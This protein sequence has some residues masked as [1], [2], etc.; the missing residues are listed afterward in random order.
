MKLK[1]VT[2]R[3]ETVVPYDRKKIES[4]VQKAVEA[5]T[6]YSSDHGVEYANKLGQE[7]AEA[8]ERKLK[9]GSILTNVEAI[10]DAV[11]TELMAKDAKVAKAF[12]LYREQ[13][14][15][16]RDGGVMVDIHK[17]IQ[18]YLGTEFEEAEQ[19]WRKKENANQRFGYPGLINYTSGAI[20][21]IDALNYLYPKEIAE[22]HKN[23]DFHIHDL[24]AGRIGYCA[25]WSLKD[26][27]EKGFVGGV[28]T[29]ASKPAK[30]L[31]SM[32]SQLFNF[33]S[34]LQAEWA[35]AQA[36]NSFDTLLAPFVRADNL[37]YKQ[38]KQAMQLFL[39][40]LNTGLRLGQCVP[41]TTKCLTAD[42]LWVNGDE[43]KV[44]DKIVVCDTKTQQFGIDTVTHITVKEY[45]GEMHE[46]YQDGFRFQ[47]T[48]DHRVVYKNSLNG[49]RC[50]IK[51]S[52][53]LV[54]SK[55]SVW[56]PMYN[57]WKQYSPEE[58]SGWIRCK[59]RKVTYSGKVWCPTTNT[60][61]FVATNDGIIKI[62]T[63]NCPFTN[64]SLDWTPHKDLKDEP[65][66]IGGEYQD[67]TYGEYQEEMNMI[68]RAFLELMI[69][70][71]KNGRV[72]TF[73]I[74][75]YNITKDFNWDSGDDSIEA[76]LFKVTG[77]YGIPYFQNFVNSDMDPSDIRA[78]CCRLRLNMKELERKTG[79]LFGAG[80][81]TGSIGVVTI[82]MPRL[83]YL[84]KDENGNPDFEKFYSR[85]DHLM[86]LASRSLELKRKE[87]W[88]RYRQGLMPY[89][90]QYL[91]TLDGHFSTIGLNGMNECCLNLF[92]KDITTPEGQHFAK[93]VLN[94]MRDKLKV[95]QEETGHIYNLEASPAEGCSTRFAKHDKEQ[96]PDII[97]AGSIVPYYTNSTQLPV[98]FTDD[99]FQALDLQEELQCLYTGGTVFHCY[100]GESEADWRAVRALVRK[101]VENYRIP[102][103]SITPTYSICP[104]HGYMSGVHKICPKCK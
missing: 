26:L 27:I 55:E 78:M 16:E 47:V 20:N 46:Y 90:Q 3:D 84:S 40:S 30:H 91:T 93:E 5:V 6:E 68:N 98:N 54:D 36:V 17:L 32:L 53:D 70:G 60:G 19:D 101:I 11:E 62:V 7:V 73:P 34:T 49:K 89:T 42:G 71:D 58:L 76:L 67:T 25:G 63:G 23:C 15:R 38:V 97:T 29:A 4:A 45:E 44:G 41:M 99:L 1:Y 96:F 31:D 9:N 21:A 100:L 2:K 88:K 81:K 72:F 95:F 24:S 80:D 52:L 28:G 22:A 86:V 103:F 57:S 77:K 66:V 13:R 82:N 51:H 10:Q 18:G 102:N 56:L 79:G 35:G 104:I 69:E 94:F 75:T 85:L 87:V 12:I 65:V 43:L 39:F 59:I 14:K 48:P 33:L 61:T 50:Y 37:T 83:G 8:V 74:P 92:G 64:I